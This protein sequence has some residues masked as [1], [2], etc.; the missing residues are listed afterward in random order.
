VHEGDQRVAL[1]SQLIGDYNAHNLLGVLAALRALGLPLVQ[2]VATV[3]ALTPVPGRLQRIRHAALQAGVEVGVEVVV[4]Y[5]HTPDALDK[6]LQALRPLARSRGGRLWCVFG[7]GGNR[8]ASKR[9]LMG[10]IAARHADLVVLTSDNPRAEAPGA[11]LAQ[12]LAGVPP[13]VAVQVIEDR[14]QAIAHAL[15]QAAPGDVVLLAG[16]GHEETQEVAGCKLPFS[17]LQEARAAL[18]RREALPC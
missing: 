5:A 7:C 2:A 3:A 12:I 13:G 18:A 1:Q 14:R 8:D 11:I 17:D 10:E 6:V 4:D 16:K 15:A 9:P